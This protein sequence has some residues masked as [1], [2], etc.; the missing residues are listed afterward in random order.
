MFSRWRRISFLVVLLSAG[1]GVGGSRDPNVPIADIFQ[2]M[3]LATGSPMGA[4][5]PGF[6][7]R[8]G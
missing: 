5:W 7:R 2:V 1:A 8:F 6:E 4:L 3:E